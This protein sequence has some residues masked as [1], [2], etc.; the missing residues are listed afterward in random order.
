MNDYNYNPTAIVIG[1]GAAGMMAA[2]QLLEQGAEVT[3]I[4]KMDRSGLKLGITGK[5]RCNVTNNCAVSDFF[6][7]VP[8]NGRFLMSAVNNFT[9]SDTMAFFENLGIPLKTERGNR[10]F[11]QSDRSLDIV[12]ALRRY[13]DKAKHIR[14][15]AEHLIIEDGVCVGVSTDKGD[16]FADRVIIATGGKSYP[17]TGSTGDG[18]KMAEQAGHTIIPPTP[19]LVPI[20]VKEK[21]CTSLMG[22]SLRNVSVQLISGSKVICDDFGELLFT[23]FGLSGPTI[24]SMSSHMAEGQDYTIRIGLKPALDDKTLD[25]RILSDFS[26]Y[27]NRDFANSLSDLLPQKLI[28]VIVKL[29]GIEGHT[30]VNSITQAQRRKLFELLRA[31]DLTFKRFRPIEEAIITSG[32][33]NVKEIN[34]KTMESK[35]VSN[36]YF[37]GEVIDVD[38]YTG[39]FNLQIAFSTAVAAAAIY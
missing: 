27:Q 30:K 12:H 10:V 7:N 1:A 25:A 17:Q 16:F 29:S 28:P 31:L 3:L 13:S 19:S 18:Y 20:E 9:P 8:R 26:K 24:L 22:L 14:A 34:P 32:G 35:L 39:G 6:T 11:P 15:R 5:G 37:A 2:G 38:A 23:H 21:W 4:E 33:V 36:L